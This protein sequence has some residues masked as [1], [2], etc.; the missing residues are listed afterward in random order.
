MKEVFQELK[1]IFASIA[2][3]VIATDRYGRILF[4]NRQAEILTGLQQAEAAGKPFG[5]S[6]RFANEKTREQNDNPFESL[7]EKNSARNLP[8]GA[9][10]V[11]HDGVQRAVEGSAAPVRD[12]DGEA[13]GA[14]LIFRDITERTERERLVQEALVHAEHI[15]ATVREPLIVLDENLRVQSANRS[16]YQTFQVSREETEDRFIF[17]LGNGQW[18]IPGLRHLLERVLPQNQKFEAFEVDHAF[19]RIGFRSMVVNAR[20]LPPWGGE[21]AKILLAI[22]DVTERRRA[23]EALRRNQERL[24]KALSIDT[25]GVLIFEEATGTLVDANDTFLRQTG[26]TREEVENRE[27]TWKKLTPPEY[28]E[29]SSDQMRQLDATGRIGPYE[30]EYYC[31]DGSRSW[32]LLPGRDS[33]MER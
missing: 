17:E 22:E 19:P 28:M 12:H 4:I 30:K 6:I 10:L 7:L 2:D 20:R 14:L 8:R 24:Q 21:D 31:K 23:E 11:R 1:E 33:M 5:T 27:L 25:I 16:F 13:I 29:A 18:N 15:F 3:A 26:F 32:M 9:M